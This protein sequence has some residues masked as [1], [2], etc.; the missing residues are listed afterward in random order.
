VFGSYYYEPLT[1][2]GLVVL[3]FFRPSHCE[4]ATEVECARSI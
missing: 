1:L 3:D 4:D 2:D